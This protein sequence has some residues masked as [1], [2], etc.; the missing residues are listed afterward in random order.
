MII[1]HNFNSKYLI[2]KEL[3]S[4]NSS[5]FL[6]YEIII[7]TIYFDVSIFKRGYLSYYDIIDIITPSLKSINK[8]YLYFGLKSLFGDKINFIKR[9][10]GKGVL[11]RY[12]AFQLFKLSRELDKLK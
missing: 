10:C 2:I 3:S 7:K 1:N 11:Y 5:K 12:L 4:N 9:S 8:N 6:F